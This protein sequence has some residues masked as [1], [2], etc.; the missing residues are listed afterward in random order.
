MLE[1]SCYNPST[2]LKVS[3]SS[4]IKCSRHYYL[5]TTS[6]LE[7]FIYFKEPWFFYLENTNWASELGHSVFLPLR[8][9]LNYWKSPFGLCS[10]FKVSP[11][12]PKIH[13]HLEP[14]NMTLRNIDMAYTIKER[15]TWDHTGLEWALKPMSMSSSETN[16]DTETHRAEDHKKTEAEIPEMQLQVKGCEG[17]PGTTRNYGKRQGKNLP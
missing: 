15:L 5:F 3:L 16:N 4:I 1:T 10:G 11:T 9:F 7:T 13:V 14:Q 2:A 12:P 6:N 17:L 8:I